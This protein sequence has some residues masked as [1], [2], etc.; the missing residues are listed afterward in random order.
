MP[1]RKKKAT[2]KVAPEEVFEELTDDQV[3]ER[4]EPPKTKKSEDAW[5]PHFGI[6]AG[7]NRRIALKS[8]KLD[9][10]E[11]LIK[12]FV[13]KPG[14]IMNGIGILGKQLLPPSMW[15]SIGSL[16]SRRNQ[17][18]ERFVRGGKHPTADLGEFRG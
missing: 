14:V 16:I 12:G 5:P 3:A 18:E 17:N 10:K 11:G 8:L 15:R 7:P 1:G 13:P 9:P 2:K 4:V 6:W